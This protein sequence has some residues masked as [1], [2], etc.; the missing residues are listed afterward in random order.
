MITTE[1]AGAMINSRKNDYR[2]NEPLKKP[3]CVI[4]YNVNM[5]LV[6]KSD[7]QISA[8]ECVRTPIKWPKKLF[9]HLLDITMLNAYNTYV[10]KTGKKSSLW[11]FSKKVITQLLE[12]Y[13]TLT[14]KRKGRQSMGHFDR[15]AA[16]GFSERHFAD[17]LPFQ[18]SGRRQQKPCF[19]CANST[20]KPKKIR[21]VTSWCPGCKVALC[22]GECYKNYHTLQKF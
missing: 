1:H 6:D 3:D 12:K 10:K 22:H 17:Q 4:D 15:L 19:V 5:R 16:V 21:K 11:L 7:M 13:G 18:E 8:V 9:F 14:V 2:T 20:I